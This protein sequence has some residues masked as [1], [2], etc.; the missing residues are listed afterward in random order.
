MQPHVV[1]GQHVGRV[2]GGHDQ[3]GGVAVEHQDPGT[4]GD[5]ARQHADDVR[6]W[7]G[8]GQI[9]HLQPEQVRQALGDVP[10]GGQAEVGDDLSEAPP[11][12][13]CRSLTLQGEVELFGGEQT[14][15]HQHVAEPSPAGQAGQ[16][17]LVGGHP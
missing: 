10:L 9:D 3:T 13:A 17:S 7:H 16:G 5:L 4:F 14:G 8:A 11:L 1:Q 12:T 6:R 15:V 2:G